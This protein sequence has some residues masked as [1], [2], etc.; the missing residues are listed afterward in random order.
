MIQEIALAQFE[1]IGVPTKILKQMSVLAYTM[2]LLYFSNLP[3]KPHHNGSM[4]Q[5]ERESFRVSSSNHSYIYI[6]HYKNTDTF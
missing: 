4:V 3:L 2:F 5:R 6:I 1:T